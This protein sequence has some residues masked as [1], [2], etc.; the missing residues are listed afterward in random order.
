[1][2]KQDTLNEIS[3]IMDRMEKGITDYDEGIQQ[4]IL[5]V[6]VYLYPEDD[7]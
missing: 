1:M 2:T 7:R 5:E 4:I 6:D 3:E